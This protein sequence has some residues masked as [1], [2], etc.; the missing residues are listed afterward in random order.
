MHQTEQLEKVQG[1]E[2]NKKEKPGELYFIFF[3]FLL[4]GAFLLE[5]FKLKGV[6]Q[7]SFNGPGA[8]PQIMSLTILFML[9]LVCIQYVRNHKE[10]APVKVVRYLFSAE[11]ITLL[12]LVTLYA[13]FLEL[14]H[15]EITTLLFLWAG[16]F[17]LERRNPLKKLIIS[18]CTL[19]LII[20]IFAYVFRVI[21]P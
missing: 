17:L 1:Q 18:V 16:M 12:V 9:F 7:G 19:G 20:L 15:F 5:S 14:L 4:T 11:V 8:I 6:L 2:I 21:M 13:L 10:A 3:L